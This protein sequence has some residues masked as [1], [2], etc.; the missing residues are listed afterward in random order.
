MC[1]QRHFD[2]ERLPSPNPVEAPSATWLGHA[3]GVD[4]PATSQW[5]DKRL[6]LDGRHPGCVER[7]DATSKD[8][9]YLLPGI[10]EFD[11]RLSLVSFGSQL[12][13]YTRSNPA[14]TGSRHVQ[15]TRSFDGGA[16]WSPFE[17]IRIDG[18]D[19][20]QGDIYFFGV[21]VNPVHNGSL[22]ATF[23]LVHRLRGCIGLAASLD[24]VRWSRVTPLLSCAIYGERTLDQPAV[25][26]LLR[27]G[28]EIWIYIHE[29]VPGI[30]FDR[31]VPL[32]LQPQLLAAEKS[33]RVVR[34]A[35]PCRLLA[36]WTDTALT[37]VL[38][39]GTMARS[40]DAECGAGGG[41][42][43]ASKLASPSQNV[44][45]GGGG[46]GGAAACNWAAR[47]PVHTTTGPNGRESIAGARKRQNGK[48]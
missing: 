4:E 1:V 23:P 8:F 15:M 27:R 33:S 44:G 24:G 21:Q 42:G 46:G 12:L 48:L 36:K 19:M 45:G 39:A 11:G 18:Y 10:C 22:I 16:S 29:E 14:S 35:F 34:Y 25:P 5:R 13:L 3:G 6:V 9:H 37:T 17:Q 32:L 20:G 26:A 31:A 47:G 41:G 28:A 7:R 2:G 43:V 30:T 40:G 38:G